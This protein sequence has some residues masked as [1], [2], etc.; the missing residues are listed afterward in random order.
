MQSSKKCNGPNVSGS[1]YGQTIRTVWNALI[2]ALMGAFFIEIATVFINQSFQMH[3]VKNQG[4]IQT[5]PFQTAHKS[6]TNC[7][8]LGCTKRCLDYLDAGVS[9]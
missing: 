1:I 8:G 2:N 9:G 5:F 6:F 3:L 4:V 7:I